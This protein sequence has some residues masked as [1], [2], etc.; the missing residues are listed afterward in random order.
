MS[1][2]VIGSGHIEYYKDGVAWGTFDSGTTFDIPVDELNHPVGDDVSLK[3]GYDESMG[4]SHL[5]MVM[6]NN[7]CTVFF[8]AETENG[9][10]VLDSDVLTRGTS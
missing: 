7:L 8:M 9:Y 2:Y 6:G 10:E 1:E 3:T 5:M 4:Y